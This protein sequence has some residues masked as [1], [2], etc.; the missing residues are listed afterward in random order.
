M[1]SSELKRLRK[2]IGAR[3]KDL[4]DILGVPFR[5]YQNWEQ[6]PESKEHRRIP[7]DAADRVRSVAQFKGSQGRV[8]FPK[9]LIWLQVPLRESE[10]K[11]LKLKA[12]LEEKNLSILIREKII[13]ILQSPLL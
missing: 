9:D 8:E 5:T 2:E 10:L 12:E 13:E 11:H 7:D 4:A 6:P 1:E 3:Q